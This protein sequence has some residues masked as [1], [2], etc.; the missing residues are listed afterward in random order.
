[1]SARLVELRKAKNLHQD[2]V[3]A[4][5][6]IDKTAVSHWETGASRPDFE[7]VPALAELLGVSVLDLIRDEPAYATIQ[8]AMEAA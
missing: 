2:D 5:L 3:A 4:K 6:G 8:A 1:M 7:K